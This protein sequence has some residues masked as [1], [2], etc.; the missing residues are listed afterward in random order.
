[1]KI[2][3]K[4]TL[5]GSIAALAISPMAL[6][7]KGAPSKADA[8]EVSE[9]DD[10]ALVDE[11]VSNEGD[12]PTS[13]VDPADSELVDCEGDPAV[14]HTADGE[15]VPI[16]W[17]RCGTGIGH[18]SPIDWVKRGGDDGEV[19]PELMFQ[20]TAGEAPVFKG[21]TAA[22]GKDLAQ[23]EKASNIEPQDGPVNPQ[24]KREKKVPVALIKKGRVFLR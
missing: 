1:M 11:E 19:N 10:D 2:K 9:V 23:D 4:F 17:V 24:V 20:N 3:A 21:E 12:E 14:C 5:I 6:A 13:N 22:I 16:D 8:P 7:G 18:G 15:G